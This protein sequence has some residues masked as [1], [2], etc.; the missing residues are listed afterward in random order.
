MLLLLGFAGI[1]SMAAT[2]R[3]DEIRTAHLIFID[4]HGKVLREEQGIDG[5]LYIKRYATEQTTESSS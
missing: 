3:P 1:G 5:E 4:N 2:H